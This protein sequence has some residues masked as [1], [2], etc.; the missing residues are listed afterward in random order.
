M[1]SVPEKGREED[2]RGKEIIE[3]LALWW[4]KGRQAL[5]RGVVSPCFLCGAPVGTGS[6]LC[7]ACW[8]FLP[9]Y[10]A[11]R[12]RTLAGVR[13]VRVGFDYVYP[14]ISLI[15]ALKFGQAVYLAPTLAQ[16]WQEF[17]PPACSPDCVI[18][19]PLSRQRWRRRGYN[20]ALE[21]AR[22]LAQWLRCPVQ[23][24]LS[25]LRATLPQAELP[26]AA[27]QSNVAGA[28]R[29]SDRLQGRQVALVDDVLTTGATL[30]AAT[31]ALH[32]VGVG[33]VDVWVCAEAPVPD[34][35]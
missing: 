27:R 7:A 18:P 26:R 32:Q 16:V 9:R 25:R 8:A 15:R 29:A 10:A 6:T 14:V 1:P 5:Y 2:S 28:F 34:P 33:G 35:F 11:T 31:A 13:R 17:P 30:E 22:P 12:R 20:Q 24:G 4:A 23:E 21:L 3:R 19:I